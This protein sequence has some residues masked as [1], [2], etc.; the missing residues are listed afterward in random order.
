M[1]SSVS[2][3]SNYVMIWAFILSEPRIFKAK[4]LGENVA[5]V[6]PSSFFPL[7][8]SIPLLPLQRCDSTRVPAAVLPCLF[9]WP[10][11]VFNARGPWK[12]HD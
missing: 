7:F 1:A 9:L 3:A 11:L 4:A 2:S 12:S 6:P 5:K 8:Q 10:S